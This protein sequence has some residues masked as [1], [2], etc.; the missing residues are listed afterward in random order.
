M[1]QLSLNFIR[2]EQ[3]KQRLNDLIE[4]HNECYHAARGGE[5]GCTLWQELDEMLKDF[6]DTKADLS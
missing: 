1:M 6:I 3:L 2:Y 4:S 5:E